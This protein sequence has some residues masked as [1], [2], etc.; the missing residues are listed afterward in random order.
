MQGPG[1]PTEN[2]PLGK[3]EDYLG[4]HW[5][6]DLS[7]FSAYVFHTLPGLN[8]CGFYL[9]DGKKLVLG[10]FQGKPACVEIAYARGVCGAA[11]TQRKPLIVP[12][13]H[14]FPGHIACDSASR[15]EMVVPLLVDGKC[16]GVFDLD[17]P[18]LERFTKSDKE[19]LEGW[20]KNLLSHSSF[21]N[22][23][24]WILET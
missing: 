15:S 1:T 2:S 11:F 18:E 7:N 21:S 4:S 5:L 19:I 13:V 8:W 17:S 3:L 22:Q 9:D 20:L 24:P 16:L 14:E 6:S 10:P 12:D 23:K